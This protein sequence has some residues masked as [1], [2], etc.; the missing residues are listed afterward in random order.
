LPHESVDKDYAGHCPAQTLRAGF[1]G[2][3]TKEV[4][5]LLA[6]FRENG[7]VLAWRGWNGD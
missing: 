5:L 2:F 7:L 4:V 6:G 3:D 1:F